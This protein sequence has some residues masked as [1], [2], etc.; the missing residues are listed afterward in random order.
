MVK[1]PKKNIL[2]SFSGGETSAFMIKYLQENYNNH[3]LIYVFANTGEENEETL[4]FVK[5]CEEFFNIKINWIEYE[6]GGY[7]IVDF[8]SAYRSHNEDEIKNKWKNHPF[9]KMITQYGI[10]NQ[11][12]PHCSRELKSVIIRKF[13][14]NK[15]YKKGSYDIAIGIRSDEIDRIGEYFY[16]LAYS[17]ITKQHVNDYW[18]KS[19]F[20][21]NLKG[22]EGNCKV[23]WKKSDRKLCTIM[24]ENPSKFDFTKQMEL[25]YHKYIP[26]RRLKIKLN[27][28]F[29]LMNFDIGFFRKNKFV[30]D[31]Y[32][33]SLTNIK[34]ATDDSINANYQTGLFDDIDESNGYSESCEA[35]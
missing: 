3:N 9:R 34:N 14:R 11:A 31:I 7:K 6:I 10:P 12:Y 30:D 28:T 5:K 1:N 4:V 21:L 32:K 20:R 18:S 26:E 15:G 2:V 29:G 19:T 16:P 13:M 23:C 27:S 33:L 24:R 8:K 22:Y 17:G 25:E 35:F